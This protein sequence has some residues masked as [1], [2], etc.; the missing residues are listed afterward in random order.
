MY[1]RFLLIR[2]MQFLNKQS[3]NMQIYLWSKLYHDCVSFKM[4]ILFT[5]TQNFLVP[6]NWNYFLHNHVV[7]C[8]RYGLSVL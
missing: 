5:H 6:S 2:E 1:C 4:L 8:A 7:M 3:K